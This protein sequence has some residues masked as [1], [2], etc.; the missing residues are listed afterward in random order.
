M[1]L[2]TKWG[3]MIDQL[4]PRRMLSAGDLDPAFG[5][6]GIFK[7]EVYNFPPGGTRDGKVIATIEDPVSGNPEFIRINND[8]TRDTS[9]GVNG[10]VALSD[11][12]QIE[13]VAVDPQTGRAAAFFRDD[14]GAPHDRVVIA[15][16][17]AT[18][19]PD[20][21]FGH[22][23]MATVDLGEI[24]QS[25]PFIEAAKFD[26]RGRLIFA[27]QGRADQL[28]EGALICVT[29]I[30]TLD[31]SF[32]V[33]GFAL[34][35]KTNVVNAFA[36]T[37]DQILY[38]G[39]FTEPFFD[40]S[41]V[42]TGKETDVAVGRMNADGRIDGSFAVD[43]A[44][45]ASRTNSPNSAT[46]V[47]G[48]SNGTVYF[49]EEVADSIVTT[50]TNE[51]YV[52]GPT[53]TTVSHSSVSTIFVAPD[54]ATDGKY[55]TLGNNPGTTGDNDQTLITRLNPDGSI[56]T[57]FGSG[58]STP[59][60][61]PDK[62][63]FDPQGRFIATVTPH[64]D[65]GVLRL[66]GDSVEIRA[67]PRRATN[68]AGVLDIA[69]TADNDVIDVSRHGGQLFV[70]ISGSVQRFSA[71]SIHLLDI[72]SFIGDDQVIVHSDVPSAYLFGGDGNDTLRG[73]D[74]NDT[75]TG[76]GGRD[77]IFGGAGNDRLNGN[78][79]NDT[80]SGD[81]GNDR[82]YGGNGNDSLYG[83]SGQDRLFG[84]AGDD[85]LKGDSGIDRLDGGDGT[86]HAT[87]DEGDVLIGIV[88]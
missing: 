3:R 24:D 59:I 50:S 32:G 18:G 62:S 26:Y 79:G 52:F 28:T 48:G 16:F 33:G 76:G 60:P 5:P 13:G 54:G 64:A 70:N 36:L 19:A 14:Q 49:T 88:T 15:M 41:G 20:A 46:N 44:I 80:L 38:A 72:E 7:A 31:S 34:I 55:Y 21:A 43:P 22:D 11:T 61:S 87:A 12:L 75:L 74:G 37:G 47:F 73:G 63:A 8:G 77:L 45:T 68:L 85:Y 10:V 56:D 1:A 53:G 57:T 42:E 71:S 23:G 27:S 65:D 58:G 67:S 40:D 17:D 83:G 2:F 69:G 30:G 39:S 51:L 4:E 6:K 9:Y 81:S 84:E 25:G 66:T 29:R 35:P 78:G 86:N 82:V